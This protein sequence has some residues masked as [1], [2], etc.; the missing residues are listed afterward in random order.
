MNL[1]RIYN[2]LFNRRELKPV[3][4]NFLPQYLLSDEH[5]RHYIKYGYAVIKNCI[6]ESFINEMTELYR[7]ISDMDEFPNHQLFFAS[8]NLQDAAIR[9]KVQNKIKSRTKEIL[10]GI[11]N[12]ELCNVETGGSLLI[13]PP[14]ETSNLG[15]HQ[16]SPIIDETKQYASYVWIPLCD[17]NEQ[18]GTLSVLPGSHLWGNHQRSRTVPSPFD[19]HPK[20]IRKYMKPVY[21][22][23][24]DAICFDSATIHSST[25][26][27]ST[28]V[29][30]AVS[31]AIFPLNHSIFHYHIDKDT[32]K[33]K[34][35]KYIVDEDFFIKDDVLKRPSNR[36]KMVAVE[37]WSG[38]Y[39][40][41]SK[42]ILK[43]IKQFQ[44]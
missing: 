9:S 10:S 12:A 38:K 29:R 11:A 26:N 18:N 33:G 2:R 17:M 21:V 15:A 32:P 44:Q 30:L 27:L 23:K 6:P 4:R 28:D 19:E 20:L 31:I 5:Y 25:A 14:S 41:T 43:L 1:Q 8:G 35:E 39:H 34:V 42:S 22:N 24:G 36:Y 7:E 13:K 3:E 40:Y 37:N 16:D